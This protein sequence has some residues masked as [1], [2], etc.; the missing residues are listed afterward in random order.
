MADWKKRLADLFERSFKEQD[1][2]IKADADEI[3]S[4]KLLINFCVP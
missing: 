2:M 1:Q 4:K 3:K